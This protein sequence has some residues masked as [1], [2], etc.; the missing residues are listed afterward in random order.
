MPQG[1]TDD[2][3]DRGYHRLSIRLPLTKDDVP[4]RMPRSCQRCVPT[5]R[6]VAGICCRIEGQMIGALA[7]GVGRRRRVRS[8]CDWLIVFRQA[9][10][11]TAKVSHSREDPDCH[12][13]IGPASYPPLRRYKPRQD[14]T[15]LQ[16]HL[17][18]SPIYQITTI[19]MGGCGNSSCSCGAD[20][21]CAAGS[22][23][24]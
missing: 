22:C 24:C 1:M 16:H 8:L 10:L 5:Q 2:W 23:S 20:C 15:Q 9:M 4:W 3:H 6:A 14:Q 21:K 17:H 13:Y 18:T 7:K 11:P 19:N 12:G